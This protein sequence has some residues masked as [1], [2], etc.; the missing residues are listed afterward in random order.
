MK[1][2]ILTMIYIGL[3]IAVG[4]LIAKYAALYPGV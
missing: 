3:A 2:E 1:E 4:V